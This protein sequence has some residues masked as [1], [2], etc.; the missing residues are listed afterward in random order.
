LLRGTREID[1]A[2]LEELETRLLLA[3][4]G[5]DCTRALIG[6]LSERLARR[7][8]S[9]PRAALECLRSHMVEL[10]APVAAP[11]FVLG[12][13][14]H[15][16]VIL[17]VGVNGA[18]KTTTIG[19]L[20]YY[21]RGLGETVVLAAADTFRAAA[22]EQLQN[23]G[24]RAGAAVISQAAGA[25]AAA[26]VF[27]ALHAA[28]A[29]GAGLVIADTAGRLHTK[30][31]LMDELRKIR[32]AIAKFDR[33]CPVETLMIIDAGTGRNSLAQAREFHDAVGLTGLV[34]SKLDGTARG[35]V[36]FALARELAVPV[37]FIGIGERPEDLRP[38]EPEPFVNALLAED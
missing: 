7:E 16:F 1:P 24:Q 9:D 6:R 26:V 36:I 14:A 32:R 3:D 30:Q 11:L 23:W 17:A 19:K 35:G 22:V 31:N 27:D 25:D 18:G 5:V 8:L 21:Y 28:R 4:V 15:P 38:F 20:A 10:L 12:D 13:A 29:R 34:V 2:L 33:Q 37:R